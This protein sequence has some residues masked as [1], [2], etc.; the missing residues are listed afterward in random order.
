MVLRFSL[1][2]FK[3]CVCNSHYLPSHLWLTS[4]GYHYMTNIEWLTLT[5]RN[6][7]TQIVLIKLVGW[8]CS[9]DPIGWNETNWMALA[10][11]HWMNETNWLQ[12]SD[13]NWLTATVQQK[14]TDIPIWRVLTDWQSSCRPLV[15]LF[16]QQSFALLCIWLLSCFC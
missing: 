3:L 9:H 5:D 4:N 8:P 11:R 14:M 6:W 10:D 13:W 1:W 16:Y 15:L 7:L 2:Q 12:V